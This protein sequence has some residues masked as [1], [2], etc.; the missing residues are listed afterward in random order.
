MPPS[1]K[2]SNTDFS[3]PTRQSRVAILLILYKTVNVVFRQ[4]VP[5]FIVIF[6]GGSEKKGDQFF[7]LA[8]GIAGISLVL[9]VLNYFRTYFFISGTDLILHSGVFKHKKTTIPFTRIQSVNFEQNM[10]HQLFNVFKVKIDTAGSDKNEFE[11][12]ALDKDTAAA[13]RD[14]VLSSGAGAQ[15]NITSEGGQSEVVMPSETIL[16]LSEMEVLKTGLTMN[17][18]R[19]G[20]LIFLFFFWIYERVSEIRPE[21]EIPEDLDMSILQNFSLVFMAIGVILLASVIISV[22]RAFAAYYDLTLVRIDGGFKVYSGLITRREVSARDHKIQYVSWSDNL[23]RRMIGMFQLTLHQVVSG[24]LKSEGKIQI[25][26]CSQAKIKSVL[27]YIFAE[28]DFHALLTNRV[29]SA[30]FYRF[31]VITGSLGSIVAAG[32]FYADY[33]MAGFFAVFLVIYLIL[34]RYLSFKKIRFGI[35]DQTIFLKKGTFG[36]TF[37]LLQVYKVQTASIAQSPYQRKRNLCSITLCTA[38]GNLT[39]PY[40]QKEVATHMLDFILYKVQSSKQHWM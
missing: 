28:H 25:P 38:A 33:T 8:M 35:D 16:K 24:E 4:L 11:F 3:L 26:G 37:T 29:H 27:Q 20:G 30:Y 7:Y 31:A 14:I 1:M 36:N 10:V 18:L 6:L 22:I 32:L 17:H 2:R 39:I 23:L 40:I 9:S 13:L 15:K 5:G 19:S 21:Q 12:H 34:S